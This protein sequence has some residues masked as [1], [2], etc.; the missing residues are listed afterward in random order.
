LPV[1]TA[2]TP[3]SASAALVSMPRMRACA[4]GERRILPW[5]MRG[6]TRSSVYFVA[7]VALPMAS[8]L[9]PRAP[10][11]VKPSAGAPYASGTA[12]VASAPG[13]RPSAA[14]TTASTILV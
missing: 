1:I 11:T 13:I 5:A 10:R 7:P 2:N 9:R 6:N 3:G 14:A 4:C 12:P 8:A